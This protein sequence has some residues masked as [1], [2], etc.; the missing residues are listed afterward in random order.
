M[1]IAAAAAAAAI[2]TR[3]PTSTIVSPRPLGRHVEVVLE[4]VHGQQGEERVR[5]LAGPLGGPCIE[6]TRHALLVPS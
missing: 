3:M 5:L 1:A 4:A 2:A 6:T